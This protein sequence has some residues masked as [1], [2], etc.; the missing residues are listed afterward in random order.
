MLVLLIAGS[1]LGIANHMDIEL[2]SNFKTPSSEYS[3]NYKNNKQEKIF[4]HGIYISDSQNRPI[5]PGIYPESVTRPPLSSPF[6]NRKLKKDMSTKKIPSRSKYIYKKTPM[7][8]YEQV[9]NN[10]L[11]YECDGESIPLDVCEGLYQSEKIKKPDCISP[12]KK[13]KRVNYFN[14][15]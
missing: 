10:Q 3:Q 8:S 4:S 7:G 14:Y 1:I 13:G 9:T 12:P 11:N 2:F 6:D 5:K 15:Q